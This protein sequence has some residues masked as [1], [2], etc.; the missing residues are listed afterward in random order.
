VFDTRSSAEG[1]PHDLSHTLGDNPVHLEPVLDRVVSAVDTERVHALILPELSVGPDGWRRLAAVVAEHHCWATTVAGSFHVKDAECRQA[2]NRVPVYGKQGELWNHE[3]R[4]F[5]RITE[6]QVEGAPHFF[7]NRD[8]ETKLAPELQEDI[9]HGKAIVVVETAMGSLAVVICADALD[10]GPYRRALAARPPDW[11]VVCAM[12]SKTERFERFAEERALQ[13]TGTLIVNAASVCPSGEM[14]AVAFMPWLEV[15]DAPPTR[16]RWL[17]GSSHLERWDFERE[18]WVEFQSTE[19][20]PYR[21]TGCGMV[22]DLGVLYRLTLH[23][24][25]ALLQGRWRFAGR[26]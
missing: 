16:M 10:P 17:Q 15:P 19:A 24:T 21:L 8:A 7:P 6:R 14:L 20:S 22:V 12:S 26:Y 5:F 13:H 25:K 4:G 9:G 3:K 23:R 1:E 11:V 2:M 18:P